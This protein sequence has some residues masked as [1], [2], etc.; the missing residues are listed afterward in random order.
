MRVR[1]ITEYGP[2]YLQ[3]RHRIPSDTLSYDLQFRLRC[4]H[5]NRTKGF[6]IVVLDEHERGHSA[7]PRGNAT[8]EVGSV[9]AVRA[10]IVAN[11]PSAARTKP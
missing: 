5:C 6:Q 8:K 7:S 10:S 1:A 11:V 4:P 2:G 3:R 9:D